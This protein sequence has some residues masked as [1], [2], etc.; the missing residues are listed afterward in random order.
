MFLLWDVSIFSNVRLSC[1]CSRHLIARQR[2]CS[3]AP[4][5]AFL[6]PATYLNFPR[7]PWLLSFDDCLFWRARGAEGRALVMMNSLYAHGE[8]M[9]T[10][11]QWW[12]VLGR[13]WALLGN[14]EQYLG[15][16]E[17]YLAVMNSTWEVISTTWQLLTVLGR[18]WA[19]LKRWWALFGRWWAL[20]G[21]WWVLLGR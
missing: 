11:W 16:D 6:L 20:L 13:W 21:R 18:W 14:D 2:P 9:S 7:V 17:H 12:T 4:S 1:R 8:V 3:P 15:G 10:T 19:L 5:R